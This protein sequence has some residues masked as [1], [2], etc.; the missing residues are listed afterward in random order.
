MTRVQKINKAIEIL[1]CEKGLDAKQ[2]HSYL[3]ERKIYVE[4]HTITQ[5]VLGLNFV[6][7]PKLTIPRRSKLQIR[8]E[9]LVEALKPVLE[10][11]HSARCPLRFLAQ[12]LNSL[13]ITVPGT[14]S[15]FT[16]KK[17]LMFLKKHNIHKRSQL[18]SNNYTLTFQEYYARIDPVIGPLKEY[19]AWVQ[20]GN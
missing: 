18:S 2:I 5:V 17:L 1:H 8:I 13:G 7:A 15:Q 12:I 16:Q 10:R 20:E 4:L 9:R 3:E 6:G 11:H 19:A 14:G